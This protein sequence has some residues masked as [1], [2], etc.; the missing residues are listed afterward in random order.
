MNAK[1]KANLFNEFFFPSPKG[2]EP[3]YSDTQTFIPGSL[4]D[5]DLD[6][7]KVYEALLELDKSK[8]TGPDGIGP[9]HNALALCSPLLH[10]RIFALYYTGMHTKMLGYSQYYYAHFPNFTALY[11]FIGP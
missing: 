9:H 3:P 1:E 8:A 6:E 7:A 4:C 2:A 10:L 11:Y 5:I